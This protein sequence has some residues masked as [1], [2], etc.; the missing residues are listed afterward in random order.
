MIYAFSLA[1][2]ADGH[3]NLG[4]LDGQGVFR[5][6]HYRRTKFYRRLRDEPKEKLSLHGRVVRYDIV[7]PHTGKVYESIHKK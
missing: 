7:C 3:Q 1:Y 6:R 5:T 4:T 2:C